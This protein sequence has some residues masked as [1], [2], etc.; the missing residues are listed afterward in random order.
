MGARSSDPPAGGPSRRKV[1]EVPLI[2]CP[3]C[4]KKTFTISGWADLDR[5]PGC[6]KPL[7]RRK[8]D[9]RDF[10]RASVNALDEDRRVSRAGDGGHR[11]SP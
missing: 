7:A 6:G 9:R 5:C 11:R 3:H 8:I 2:D 10:D 4:D 1:H